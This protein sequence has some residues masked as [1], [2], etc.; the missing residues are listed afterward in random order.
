M[1]TSVCISGV[2]PRAPVGMENWNMVGISRP[3]RWLHAANRLGVGVRQVDEEDKA[4]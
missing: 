4:P 2:R 3:R 1:R